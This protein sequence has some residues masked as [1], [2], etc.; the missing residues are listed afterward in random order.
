MCVY[1]QGR[2][3]LFTRLVPCGYKVEE[4]LICKK[5]RECGL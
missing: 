5:E 2:L 1:I 3:V 4:D